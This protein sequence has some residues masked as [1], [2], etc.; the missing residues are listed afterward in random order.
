MNWSIWQICRRWYGREREPETER[1]ASEYL[2]FLSPLDKSQCLLDAWAETVSSERCQVRPQSVPLPMAKRT[3][4]FVLGRGYWGS[5]KLPMVWVCP[6]LSSASF[7]F[8][9]PSSSVSISFVTCWFPPSGLHLGVTSML[10]PFINFVHSYGMCDT[11]TCEWT[12]DLLKLSKCFSKFSWSRSDLCFALS[13][14]FHC[15]QIW[16][17][18]IWCLCG[19]DSLNF[20]FS[21]ISL[22]L[23]TLRAEGKRLSLRSHWQDPRYVLPSYIDQNQCETNLTNVLLDDF[24]MQLCSFFICFLQHP[25]EKTKKQRNITRNIKTKEA[26][27]LLFLLSVDV[28]K[29]G[30]KKRNS[31]IDLHLQSQKKGQPWIGVVPSL[32]SIIKKHISNRPGTQSKLFTLIIWSH[33]SINYYYFLL[34]SYSAAHPGVNDTV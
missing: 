3:Q 4:C 33:Y 15:I 20:R 10:F 29:E 13:A 34:I 30:E 32:I 7:I 8:L 27:Q 5:S 24:E 17:D 26:L 14:V 12:F 22:C 25:K 9:S 23:Q 19:D 21:L 2:I 31:T 28:T 11:N 6:A 18:K 16:M 1:K